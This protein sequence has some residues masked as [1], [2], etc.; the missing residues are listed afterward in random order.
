LSGAIDVA[1]DA[2][3]AHLADGRATTAVANAADVPSALALWIDA[4]G[5]AQKLVGTGYAYGGCAAACA[6]DAFRTALV[7]AWSKAYAAPSDGSDTAHFTLTASAP[8]T[9]GDAA[10]PIGFSGAWIGQAG[11][12]A[13]AASFA[14]KGQVA[15]QATSI[16]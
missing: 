9:V 2:L 3:L 13:I 1:T 11:G 15:A 4:A 14:L 10:Q 12:A 8:A 5:L 6:A 16:H 7:Q